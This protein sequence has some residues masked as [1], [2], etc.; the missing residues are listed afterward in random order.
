MNWTMTYRLDSDVLDTYGTVTPKAMPSFYSFQ[1][2]REGWMRKHVM[3]VWPVS[4]CDTFGKREHF[5]EELRKYM[6]VD[7]YGQCGNY[8]CPRFTGCHQ[9]F[10]TK[11]FFRLSFENTLCKDYVTEKLFYTLNF[12]MIPVTFG[13]ADYK[14]LA[15]PNSYIDALAFKT[16]KDLADY[17]KRVSEDF[18]LY[19]SY[20]EWKGVYDVKRFTYYTF[21]NLCSKLYSSSFMERSAYPDIVQWWNESSQCRAWNRNTMELS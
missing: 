9:K 5:V 11:Y 6:R 17:L 15:P 10:A 8:A 19:K 3:A 13:G 4:H 18:D 1:R 14:A 12:D 2:L 16:P 21:C 20:F 7:V